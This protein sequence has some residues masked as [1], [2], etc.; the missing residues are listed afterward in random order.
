MMK[1]TTLLLPCKILEPLQPATAAVIWLH[2]L[3]ASGDDFFRLVPQL[4]L[5]HNHSIR[6]IFPDAPTR[7]VTLNGGH[8]MPAWYDITGLTLESREDEPGI[9]ETDRAIKLL[10][11]QQIESGI[12]ANRII[13]AGFS[14][15]GAIALFC[16]L[17]YPEK[18]AGV[19]AL[20]TYLPLASLLVAERSLAN[21]MT[22]IFIAHG[23][24][25]NVVPI[26]WAELAKNQLESVGHPVL[27][28]T[29]A[30]DHSLCIEEVRE[31]AAWLQQILP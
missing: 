21:H 5:P 13:L 23:K 27:W 31:I 26:A 22:P 1:A 8:Q 30:M 20:S 18:I 15:G 9:R 4:H 29:Y 7:P 10:I 28:R 17:R 19:L 6:F 16:G 11:E 12:P 3:G 2:G 14:Q 25:D 24:N